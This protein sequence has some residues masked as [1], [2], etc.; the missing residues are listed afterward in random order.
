MT[1]RDAHLADDLLVRAMDDELFPSESAYVELHLSHCDGCRQRYQ[2]L[3]LLSGRIEALAASI[4]PLPP[5]YGRVFLERKL[6]TVSPQVA[7]AAHA[8]VMRRFGWGMAVAATLAIGIIFAPG[9]LDNPK[10]VADPISSRRSIE[11]FDVNGE[12]F[13]ALPYS[14]SDLPVSSSHIVEMQ[15][16]MSSLTDAGV[17][18]ESI[19]SQQTAVDHSVLA[20]VLIGMDGQPLGVHVLSE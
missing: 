17:A 19:S 10:A 3:N 7:S 18:F 16:P 1:K 5:A 9:K 6:D 15:V 13:V 4:A 2:D 12:T 14:N 11:T 20:D 8:K